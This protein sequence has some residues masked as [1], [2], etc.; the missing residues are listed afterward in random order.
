MQAY[1]LY[2]CSFHGAGALRTIR[3]VRVLNKFCTRSERILFKT[4]LA[5]VEIFI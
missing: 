5:L 4:L 2:A 3:I 1:L